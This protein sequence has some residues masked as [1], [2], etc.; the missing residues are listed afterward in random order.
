MIISL[1][2]YRGSGKSSIAPLLAQ[3]R[4]W[5][6][7]DA[8][9]ELEQQAKKTISEIFA[10]EGEAG[11]RKREAEL[12]QQLY[13]QGNL[14]LATGGGA[15]LNPETRKLMKASGPVIWLQADLDTILSRTQQDSTTASSRPALTQLSAREEIENLLA[16]RQE[17]YQQTSHLQ[18]QTSGKSL[19][20]IAAE[21]EIGLE[22]LLVQTENF[23]ARSL[24][25]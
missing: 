21:I 16:S 18:I 20:E 22:P 10:L 19:Q 1:I 13:Q 4:G 5:R 17:F 6:V 12:L 24:R 11:F 14:V 9:R 7:V 23:Q 25:T 8:D 2:G 3:P 15:I